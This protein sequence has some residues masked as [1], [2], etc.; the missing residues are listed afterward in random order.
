MGLSKV[1]VLRE[2]GDAMTAVDVRD[3]DGTTTVTNG[4]ADEE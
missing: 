2:M 4:A 3:G 1:V